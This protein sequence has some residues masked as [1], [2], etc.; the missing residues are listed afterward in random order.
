MLSAFAASIRGKLLL[1]TAGVTFIALFLA[2]GLLV[3]YEARTYKQRWVSDLETQADILGTSTSAALVFDDRKTATQNLELLRSRKAIQEAAVYGEDGLLFAAFVRDP[4]ARVPLDITGLRLGSD[5]Q[6]DF[7]TIIKVVSE[8]G[9]DR[10][11]VY[12]R[13]S[14]ELGERLAGYAGILA[15][16]M[17]LSLFAAVAIGSWLQR[18]ITG[19]IVAVAE[20][21]H[22]V[23]STRDFSLRV[24]RR[25]TDEVAYL[26]DAFNAMLAEIGARSEALVQAD[27]MKDQFL[28]TLAHELR[29]PLAPIRNALHILRVAKHRPELVDQA[30]SMMER[31]VRQLVRLV[32]DLLDVSRITTGKLTLHREPVA[33]ADVVENAIEIARPVIE[34]QRHSL[35]VRLPAE[36]V[37]LTADATRLAQVFSNLLNNAAKYTDSGGRIELSAELCGDNVRVEVRDNGMGISRELLPDVFNMF[38]QA[39]A[40]LRRP[41]QS[42]LGVGLALVK[43]LVELHGGTIAADSEGEGRGSR[44]SVTLPRGAVSA[45]PAA[46]KL[47][48]HAI[49]PQ[50]AHRVVIIDDNA[51]FAD[52][53]AAI[54]AERGDEVRLAYDGPPGLRIVEE[55]MPDVAFVDVGLPTMS[56]H[57]V[58]RRLRASPASASIVLVAVSGWGQESDKA[59][60]EAAGF[61]AHIVKPLDP[62]QLDSIF[63]HV[64]RR[65][66]VRVTG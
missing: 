48:I 50:R 65:Q 39:D 40:A 55:F 24:D 51:D 5:F 41:T 63:Q 19:P 57:D 2:G 30:Q 10:G 33:L 59:R 34:A 47:E 17:L 8:K 27:R 61:D 54:L 21:A 11:Y 35:V 43:R 60:S 44:F 66:A 38:T 58:A 15:A 3:A 1:L 26:V 46:A 64:R 53:L 52:S 31:Q 22:R 18:R 28:A 12:V 49:A 14:H 23:I 29:N 56:G 6:G 37:M 7:V 42:G 25:T 16:V 62:A 45:A 4:S 20:T 32:D 36:K 9:K 13:A